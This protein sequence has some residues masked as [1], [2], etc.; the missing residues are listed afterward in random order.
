MSKPAHVAM[1]TSGRTL[2][3]RRRPG[4]PFIRS[5]TGCLLEHHGALV[6][7]SA[8]GHAAGRADPLQPSGR[9]EARTRC[10][11]TTV[12]TSH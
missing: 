8:S 12:A 6:Q 10:A 11:T 3:T 7:S 4:E 9:N 1:L 2:T 5:H